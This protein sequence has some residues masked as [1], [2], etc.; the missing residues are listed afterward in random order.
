MFNV[1]DIKVNYDIKKEQLEREAKDERLLREI[2]CEK[3]LKIV[4]NK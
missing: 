1:F 3:T 2:E 4:S